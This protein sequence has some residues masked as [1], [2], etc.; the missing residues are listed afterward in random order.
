[1]WLV[2]ADFLR[3]SKP[4]RATS[5]SRGSVVGRRSQPWTWLRLITALR[6]LTVVPCLG[7]DAEKI[8]TAT[9]PP[10]I[11][12]ARVI[13]WVMSAVSAA[14]NVVSRIRP[15]HTAA[16]PIPPERDVHGRAGHSALAE[17]READAI[18]AE[19][20]AREGGSDR[21]GDARAEDGRAH[22]ETD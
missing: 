21:E 5:S 8:C 16:N 12:A 10:K 19:D 1:M 22:E 7:P 17:E 11:T 13:S 15:P 14:M 3:M 2:R 20:V 18:L 4:R 9:H 6:M